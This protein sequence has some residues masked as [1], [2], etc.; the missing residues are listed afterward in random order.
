[1]LTPWKKSYD[2]PKQHMKKQ[3]YY[4]AD[5]DPSSQSYGFSSSHVQIWELDH[6]EGW[7]PEDWHFQIVVLEKTLESLLES[8]EIKLVSVL[9]EINPKYSSE[10]LM[11]K[12]KLQYF[13][14]LMERADSTEKTLILGKIEGRKR[15]GWQRMRWQDG[16]IDSMDMSLSKLG[17]TVNGVQGR[18]VCYSPWGCKELDTMQL[19]NNNN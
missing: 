7:A 14:H 19:L 1:M 13:G 15:R 17:E 6:K 16:I 18:L 4:F 10:G 2:K 8:K 3:R 9:K 5:K 12:L 11:L